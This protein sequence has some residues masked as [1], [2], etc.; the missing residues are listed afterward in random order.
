MFVCDHAS[1][2]NA[3][4]RGRGHTQ[5]S[6]RGGFLFE[7]LT[8][9][10]QPLLRAISNADSLSWLLAWILAFASISVRAHCS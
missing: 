3:R 9:C 5:G 8:K 10:L 2:L 6:L 7:Q 4:A 1:D